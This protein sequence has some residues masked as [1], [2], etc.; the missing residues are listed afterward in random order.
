MNFHTYCQWKTQRR[1]E[2]SL[3]VPYR[4]HR[5]LLHPK[6]GSGTLRKSNGIHLNQDPFRSLQSLIC[7]VLRINFKAVFSCACQSVNDHKLKNWTRGA[8]P[9]VGMMSKWHSNVFQRGMTALTL[10]HSLFIIVFNSPL[11]NYIIY[12]YYYIIS[13]W[14]ISKT[15]RQKFKLQIFIIQ[16]SLHIF[17]WSKYGPGNS[18]HTNSNCRAGHSKDRAQQSRLNAFKS[19]AGFSFENE[20]RKLVFWNGSSGNLVFKGQG[21]N[22]MNTIVFTFR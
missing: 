11:W 5:S 20:T 19:T 17:K 8:W 1:C 4:R 22:G 16:Y 18:S 7:S 15:K 14:T 13:S 9:P 6:E 3:L 21:F 12:L 2:E 10:I